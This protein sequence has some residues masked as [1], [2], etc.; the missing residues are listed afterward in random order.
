[1]SEQTAEWIRQVAF[2]F[3]VAT[4]CVGFSMSLRIA[5]VRFPKL[6]R[7]QFSLREL[8]IM[9]FAMACLMTAV[10]E[11][12]NCAEEIKRKRREADAEVVKWK[13]E[14]YYFR[15]CFDDQAKVINRLCDNRIT[16]KEFH[17]LTQG[18]IVPIRRQFVYDGR[19]E[20]RVFDE[21][22]FEHIPGIQWK[23]ENPEKEP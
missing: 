14:S 10:F 9:S 21:N 12:Y 2:W 22:R 19:A 15:I 5:G 23:E 6:N 20:D 17:E 16:E 4:M 1:M 18:L 11:R 7:F 3:I 13:D 8:F